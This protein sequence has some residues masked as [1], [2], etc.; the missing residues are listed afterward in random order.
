MKCQSA[1]CR[2]P[3]D[4]ARVRGVTCQ[5][6]WHGGEPE[7]GPDR[8][9][10]TVTV[11]GQV[12][13]FSVRVTTCRAPN[14][15]KK[16]GLSK[17][18]SPKPETLNSISK[19]QIHPKPSPSPQTF[20]L[21]PKPESIAFK[22]LWGKSGRTEGKFRGKIPVGSHASGCRSAG[23]RACEPGRRR[24]HHHHHHHHQHQHHHQER[25]ASSSGVGPAGPQKP[26]AAPRRP[27][28]ARGRRSF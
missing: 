8:A 11:P 5:C 4:K 20:S 23:L 26:P 15:P 9:V 22:L 6:D 16:I 14:P 7:P 24:R 10:F 18:L 3:G 28:R 13:G 21:K 25:P 1:G 12:R 19:H 2:G 27:R 17:I